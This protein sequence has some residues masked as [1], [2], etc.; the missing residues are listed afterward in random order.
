MK[1]ALFLLC[2]GV[3]L[4]SPSRPYFGVSN[5]RIPITGPSSVKI[6]GG[7]DAE[8]G[9]YPWQISL[10][11]KPAFGA[12]YHTCGGTLIS[13]KYVVCAAHCVKGQT[14]SRLTVVVGAHNVKD[15]SEATQQRVAVKSFTFNPDYNAN[16]IVND[17]SVIELAEPVTLNDR[18]QPLRLAPA[19]SK[20]EG[21]TCINTGWGNSRPSGGTPAIV[22]DQLQEVELEILPQDECVRVYSGINTVAPGMICGHDRAGGKGACNGDSGGPLVC[23][24]AD[25]PYLAGIVSWGMQPCAQAK[26][27]SV[28]TRVSSYLQFVQENTQ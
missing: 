16:T 8:P 28:Y 4:A 6:V 18:V 20:P 26:Y 14:L 13:E 1:V 11:V 25:G 17:V 27:P 21:E 22:P 3:A 5:Q 15:E 9:E 23:S 2:V 12:R 19:D 10:Q 7:A 24:D